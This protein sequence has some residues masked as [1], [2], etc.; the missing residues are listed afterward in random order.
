[1]L[2]FACA[3]C[4]GRRHETAILHGSLRTPHVR[5]CAIRYS[6]PQSTHVDLL[7]FLWL[8]LSN[9]WRY[10]A[11]FCFDEFACQFAVVLAA[12]RCAGHAVRCGIGFSQST[13]VEMRYKLGAGD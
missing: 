10:A 3:G 8:Q 7:L 5:P 2:C 9:D 13:P 11:L 12:K 4:G 6:E 1:K